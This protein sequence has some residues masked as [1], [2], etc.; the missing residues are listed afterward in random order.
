MR[1]LRPKPTRSNRDHAR[2]V[3][4]IRT[5]DIDRATRAHRAHRQHSAELLTDLLRLSEIIR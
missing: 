3:E 2:V 1:N 5:G 4:A